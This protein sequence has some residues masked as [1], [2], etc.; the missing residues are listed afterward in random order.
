MCGE[1][2]LDFQ[3]VGVQDEV[4]GDLKADCLCSLEID[5]ELEPTRLFNRNGGRVC[6]AQYFDKL[7]TQQTTN[8]G[9]TRPIAD[10]ATFFR[11]LRPLVH[12]RQTQF[13]GA[14]NDHAPIEKKQ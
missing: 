1:E 6:A 13:V 14:L 11:H 8:L 12:C 4:R 7:T 9:E 5:D 10:Q 2:Q 3:L